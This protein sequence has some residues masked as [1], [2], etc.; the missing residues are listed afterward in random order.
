ML[1]NILHKVFYKNPEIK[2]RFPNFVLRKILEEIKGDV[3]DIGTGDGIKLRK[4][5]QNIPRNRLGEIFAIEINPKMYAL[6]KENLQDI[7]SSV[8]N[9]DID[10]FDAGKKFDTILMFEVLEHLEN[11]KGSLQKIVKLL[12]N[13]GKLILTVPNKF[14]YDIL[15]FFKTKMISKKYSKETSEEIGQAHLSEMTYSQT[16]ALLK[17]LFRE[18]EVYGIYPFHGLFKSKIY[19]KVNEKTNFLPISSRILAVCRVK[20][21]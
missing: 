16:T 21:L 9:I 20:K 18:V 7:C 17:E 13:N 14:I 10:R 11:P 1:G 2:Y 19:E 5:I 6:A 8:L 3:L 12:K 4:I 15:D